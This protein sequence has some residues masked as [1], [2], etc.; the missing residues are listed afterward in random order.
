MCKKKK[1]CGEQIMEKY[2]TA[3]T[4]WGDLEINYILT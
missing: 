3:T 1:N 4:T 2:W